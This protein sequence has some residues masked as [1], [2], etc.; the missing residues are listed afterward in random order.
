[1]YYLKIELRPENILIYICGNGKKKQIIFYCNVLLF[2]S[3]IVF[4]SNVF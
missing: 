3:N 2:N 1:M 4:N